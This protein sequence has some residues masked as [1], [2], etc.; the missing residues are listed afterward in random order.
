VLTIVAVTDP[1]NGSVSID[2]KGTASPGDDE[3]IY[4]PDPG[5]DNG[6]DTFSY[7]VDDGNGGTATASVTVTVPVS[8]TDIGVELS[9]DN[10]NPAVNDTVTLTLTVSNQ[11]TADASVQLIN[12]LPD[13]LSYAGDDSG[14]SFNPI[15][16][17][18]NIDSLSAG[19]TAALTITATVNASGDYTNTA[20]ISGLNVADPNPANNQASITFIL[21]SPGVQPIPALDWRG[22]GLLILLSLLAAGHYRRRL[23][24]I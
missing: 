4:T 10:L 15:T 13:G 23:A 12:L 1:P 22:L 17:L 18:W 6:T 24:G 21:A 5:F 14:G 16:G 8:T 20:G 9:A 7:T 2:D 3:I 19:D 11:G